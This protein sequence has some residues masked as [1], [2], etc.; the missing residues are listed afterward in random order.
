[1]IMEL[2]GIYNPMALVLASSIGL[3]IVDPLCLGYL[4]GPLL[5]SLS[6]FESFVVSPVSCLVSILLHSTPLHFNSL[7]PKPQ[8]LNPPLATWGPSLV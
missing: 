5:W 6:F 8:L 2:D 3:S 4:H 7:N 1:M